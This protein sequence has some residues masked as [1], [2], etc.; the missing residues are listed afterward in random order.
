[1]RWTEFRNYT[2]FGIF[3]NDP[4]H[5]LQHREFRS[6]HVDLNE[7][8]ALTRTHQFVKGSYTDLDFITARCEFSSSKRTMTQNISDKKFA[9]GVMSSYSLTFTFYPFSQSVYG[10]GSF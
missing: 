6:F 5:T 3:G 8:N 4:G 2:E 10:Q 7:I 9:T 1:M